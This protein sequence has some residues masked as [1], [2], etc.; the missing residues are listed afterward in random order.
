MHALL[1]SITD[2]SPNCQNSRSRNSKIYNISCKNCISLYRKRVRSVLNLAFRPTWGHNI[3][4]Y[5]NRRQGCLGG[6]SGTEK[7]YDPITV[8]LAQ[9]SAS[10]EQASKLYLMY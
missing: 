7:C 6:D 3:F 1:P 8:S 2:R 10:R 9:T 4:P 5:Q